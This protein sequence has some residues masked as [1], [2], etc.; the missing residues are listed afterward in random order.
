MKT[1]KPEKKKAED[2]KNVHVRF[3]K[4]EIFARVKRACEASGFPNL[5]VWMIQAAIEKADRDLKD[6]R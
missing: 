4:R 1:I 3:Y 2:L 6:A 5:S